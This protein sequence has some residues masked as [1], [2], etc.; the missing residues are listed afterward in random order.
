MVVDGP[1]VCVARNIGAFLAKVN[2]LSI[3]DVTILVPV[4]SA[5][6][7]EE[8]A[9]VFQAQTGNLGYNR[10]APYCGSC[11][12]NTTI[13]TTPKLE[14]RIATTGKKLLDVQVMGAAVDLMLA[15]DGTFNQIY[16]E[17]VSEAR[18]TLATNS[19][20]GRFKINVSCHAVA[21]Q[22]ES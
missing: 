10:E 4:H 8:L 22:T 9:V 21:Y 20:F 18:D 19:R 17:S 14:A 7:R 13:I 16:A 2:T 5:R 1:V 15:L 6:L 11:N 3:L 12:N